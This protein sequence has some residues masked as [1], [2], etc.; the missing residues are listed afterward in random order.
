VRSQV[1]TAASVKMAVWFLHLEVIPGA[2]FAHRP[3]DGANKSPNSRQIIFQTT[4]CNNPEDSHLQTG[5]KFRIFSVSGCVCTLSFWATGGEMKLRRHCLTSCRH[6]SPR[7]HRL[8]T[9]VSVLTSDWYWNMTDQ[10]DCWRNASSSSW[11]V[12][13]AN[14]DSEKIWFYWMNKFFYILDRKHFL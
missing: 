12:I 10:H 14:R 6:L 5:W 9:G 13:Q 2:R 11:R 7:F 8:E 1:L 3:D 4:R